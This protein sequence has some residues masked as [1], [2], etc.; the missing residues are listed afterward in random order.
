MEGLEP[1]QEWALSEDHDGSKRYETL[2]TKF[3]GVRSLTL[4]F[5]RNFGGDTTKIYYIGLRGD[6]TKVGGGKKRGGG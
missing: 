4:Y 1:T 2:L 3:N 6:A 5:N